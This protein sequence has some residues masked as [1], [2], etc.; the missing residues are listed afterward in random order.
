MLPRGF[1]ST[2]ISDSIQALLLLFGLFVFLRCA[3]STRGRTRV[4]WFLVATGMAC[5]L[6]Y[7]LLWSYYEVCLRLTVPDIFVGDIVLFLH[8]VPMMAAFAMQPQ[9]TQDDRTT[10]FR[11]LDFALLLV[12]WV[13]LYLFTV[14]PW[15]Y[16][17]PDQYAYDHN[18]NLIYLA[19][20]VVFLGGLALVWN[21]S[22]HSWRTI[23]GL[24]FGA[25]LTY[26]LS[27]YLAN[28]AIEAQRY[29]SGS[30]YDIPLVVAMAWFAA[31]GLLAYDIAPRQETAATGRGLGVW[32]AHL[33]MAAILSLPLLA[34][35]TWFDHEVPDRV[36]TFR[37][38][39]TLGTM[40]V[41]GAMVFLRQ[42]L[43]DRELLN[44]LQASRESVDHL[45]RLQ[46]QLVQSEKLAS[47]GQ[48][49][50]GAAHE[51]NNPLTA[52]IGYSDLLTSTQLTEEQRSLAEKISQ[53]VRRTKALVASLL[54]FARQVPGEKSP[55]DVTA[56]VQTAVKLS[57]PQL[58]THN[59]EI[60][61]ELGSGLPSIMGDSNQLLQVCLHIISNA[62][63]AL[64]EVGGG[65]LTISTW[66]E[67][68]HV[69]LEFADTG[70]GAREP[71]RVFDPFYTTRPVGQGAGLGLSASYGIVHEHKGKI[72]C[73]NRPEGGVVFRIELPAVEPAVTEQPEPEQAL[74]KESPA[75][76]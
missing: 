23:F 27:S 17:Y 66:Q 69:V 51:L 68:S 64:E 71:Q 76:R 15:Q 43:L 52:M 65:L 47:L 46:A 70:P 2:V 42:H 38:L 67:Q 6:T 7:Q 25:G 3:L 26:A 29:Y 53:Q 35:W 55:L 75:L 14:I 32:V 8:L 4:F 74:S 54:S 28:F 22:R 48:L 18:F 13:F 56:L 45:K 39:V 60:R 30:F 37:L 63:H 16:A 19:E 62:V 41:M 73:H 24:W 61:T 34:A 20:K 1:A 31:V 21:R 10:R 58:R 11:A 44:L 33:G 59:V 9:R 40:I 49:V 12:W 36:R 50:G 57:Q 5:W 72:F